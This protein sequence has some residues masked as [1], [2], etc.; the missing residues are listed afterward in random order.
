MDKRQLI[1]Q[2]RHTQLLLHNKINVYIFLKNVSKAN[3]YW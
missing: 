3:V 1:H 2:T